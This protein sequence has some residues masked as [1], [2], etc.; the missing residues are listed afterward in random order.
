MLTPV[1]SH[2]SWQ[3]SLGSRAATKR[4]HKAPWRRGLIKLALLIP[5]TALMFGCTAAGN[6]DNAES[7]S[8]LVLNFLNPTSDPFADV[9]ATSGTILDDTVE[10]S[11]S[12]HLKHPVTTNPAI[13]LPELQEIVLERYEVVYERTDGGTAVPPG[14]TRDISG[15]V[16]LTELGSTTLV[17]TI[18]PLVIMPSTTKAQPPISFLIEPG[19]E[20]GTNFPNI[21]MNAK[22]TFFGRTLSGDIVSVTGQIGMNFANYGDTNS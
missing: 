2:S 9:I 5:I 11:F 15:R 1:R 10:V 4:R 19:I 21:Q 12:A 16:R 17:E 20:P 14:F 22:V 13:I 3:T 7:A 8:F 18:M 6:V